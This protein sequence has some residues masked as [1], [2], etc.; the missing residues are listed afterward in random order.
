LPQI[1]TSEA[2]GPGLSVV[3][4]LSADS[5]E[6]TVDDAQ[7]AIFRSQSDNSA[8]SVRAATQH[9]ANR[10]DPRRRRLHLF[11]NYRSALRTCN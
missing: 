6:V 9:T 10:A 5:L 3:G 8:V 2:F 1:N 11:F 7:N 4:H